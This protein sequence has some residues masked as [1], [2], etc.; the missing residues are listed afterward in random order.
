[1]AAPQKIDTTRLPVSRIEIPERLRDVD[2]K[3][4][5][6]IVQS[7]SE[8]QGIRDAIHVRKTGTGYVLVDGRHRLAACP[9]LGLD[10]VEAVIWKCTA[11]QA[12]FME[13]DANLSNGF[14]TPL[15]MAVSL[16]ERKRVYEKMYPETRR[17][18]ASAA[19]RQ[20]HERTEM[21]F[22]DYVGEVI[23]ITARQA[24]RI[25]SAGEALESDDVAALQGVSRHLKMND[26]YEIAKVSEDVERREV[27]RVL[28]AGKA[29]TASKARRLYAAATG[30][31]PA[32]ADPVDA[33]FQAL[34][35]AWSR[36]RKVA[37]ERFAAHVND[38]LRGIQAALPDAAG[39]VVAFAHRREA[40]D[41]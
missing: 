23:G 12:R 13:A 3:K 4:V 18:A 6:L 39:E 10:D 7:A 11:D 8:G 30:D 9:R 17:G 37:R 38:E 25:A 34:L 22:C 19:A 5:D 31:A 1:M 20:G 16:A 26:L 28:A 21:S 32:P 35:K 14:L 36:A 2:P 27:V 40:A 33:E 24:R 15:D 41:E 29:K